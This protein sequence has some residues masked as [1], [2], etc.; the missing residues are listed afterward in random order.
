[1]AISLTHLSCWWWGSK[2]KE[3]IPNGPS[4][5]SLLEKW[6]CREERRV[7]REFDI[8]LVPSD[9]VCLSSFKYDGSNVSIGWMEPHGNSFQTDDEDKTAMSLGKGKFPNKG[10]KKIRGKKGK[11]NIIFLT[12][13]KYLHVQVT[14]HVILTP[15]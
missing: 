7:D 5:N 10:K 9:G 15:M 11:K 1:M 12:F 13:R 3:F 6:Q 2:N 8:V 14:T 4:I